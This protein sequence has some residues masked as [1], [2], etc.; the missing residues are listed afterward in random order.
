V[1]L[2]LELQRD[3]RRAVLGLGDEA[4][5]RWVDGD[6][7]AARGR[8]A[9]YRHHVLATLTAVL[10]AAFPVVCRLVDERFFA[11]AADAYLRRQPPS[12]PCLVEYGGTFPAFLAGF[13]A[14]RDLPYLADVARLEW[15]LHR[16]FHAPDHVPLHAEALRV[17]A[18]EV[19]GETVLAL[20][21]SVSLVAS[22]W[23]IGRIWRANQPEADPD[24]TVNLGEGGVRLEVRRAGEVVAFRGLGAAVFAFRQAIAEGRR[25]ADAV[26]RAVALDEG[27]DLAAALAALVQEGLVAGL[28]PAP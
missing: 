1:A 15:A 4:A 7:V 25:L 10:E 26:G 28:A 24:A 14:C 23:P 20:D 22:P 11:Y 21:P 6:A 18:A 13:P 8:L 19:T 9:I 2:L 16:A 3:V 5:A 17:R 27:F 12:G